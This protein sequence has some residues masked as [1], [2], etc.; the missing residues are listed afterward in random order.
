MTKLSKEQEDLVEALVVGAKSRE[1]LVGEQGILRELQ[2][3]FM[4]RALEAELT[5]HL[6]YE[7]NEEAGEQTNRRNGKG[8]KRVQTATAELEIEVPRDREGTFDPQLVRKRQRRLPEFDDKVIALYARGLSTREIQRQLEDLYGV[9]VS[10]ALISRVTDAVL[11]DAKAWQSRPLSRCYPIVYFDALFVKSRQDGAVSNKAVYLALGLNLEGEKEVLGLWIQATEGAK[12]WLHVFT[13]LRNRGMQDCLV[14]CCDGLAGLP[15]AIESVFPETQVQLCIVHQVRNSL[16]YVVWKD[17]KPVASALRAIYSAPTLP[18]A[19]LAREAFEETWGAKYP[20]IGRSWHTNWSRLTTLFDYPPEI[21]RVIY[22]TNAIESLN[23][24]LR[25]VLKK[26]GAF[27]TDES[28][29]KVLYLALGHVARRWTRPVRN[30]T[31]AM[32]QFA[33]RYGDRVAA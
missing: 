3:R 28:I 5:E 27:P 25:K 29:L 20:A 18:E 13:E 30:W 17:R 22:T 1:E 33:I 6:G 21:R 9:E 15:E 11:E 8:R 7:A 31:A 14:A 12:F 32:N 10:P 23:Y 4:Q 16:K 19:E 26:R 2:K 24:T